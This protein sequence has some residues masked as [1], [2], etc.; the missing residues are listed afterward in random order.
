MMKGEMPL[1]PPVHCVWLCTHQ[2]SGAV[3]C[4]LLPRQHQ[5]CITAGVD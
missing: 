2:H 5:G 3:S 1:L 4:L